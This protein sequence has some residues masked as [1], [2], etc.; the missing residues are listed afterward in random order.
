MAIKKKFKKDI[1]II[2]AIILLP[3]LTYIYIFFPRQKTINFLGYQFSSGYY[4]DVEAFLWTLM[5]KLVFVLTF[6]IWFTTC[7]HWWR[8]ILSVPII[9]F[10]SKLIIVLNDDLVFFR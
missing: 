8:N 1:V 7:K 2:I 3:L 9:F 5:Q 10:I 6:L 4:G